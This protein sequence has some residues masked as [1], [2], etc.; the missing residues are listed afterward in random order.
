MYFS[1]EPISTSRSLC[2]I[3]PGESK[4]NK[5]A[6]LGTSAADHL[7]ILSRTAPLSKRMVERSQLF[8]CFRGALVFFVR[9]NRSS[10][11]YARDRAKT[12]LVGVA[13]SSFLHGDAHLW[14]VRCRNLFI[15]YFPYILDLRTHDSVRR[16][17]AH[18][19]GV[20]PLGFPVLHD[21]RSC[22]RP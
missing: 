4:S 15:S 18:A 12:I 21:S 5:V 11:I 8:A 16:L 3:G 17:A 7:A 14:R 1:H 10:A 2:S 9:V 20:I 19:S 13:N 6:Y 22:S